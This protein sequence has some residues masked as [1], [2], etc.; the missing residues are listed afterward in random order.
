[1]T[2][3]QHPND[4]AQAQSWSKT[5][6]FRDDV[7]GKG[8]HPP[9]H[10]NPSHPHNPGHGPS[11]GTPGLPGP[12]H[13]GGNTHQ[14]PQGAVSPFKHNT[15]DHMSVPDL[16]SHLQRA[17]GSGTSK[18]PESVKD[19]LK[20]LGYSKHY[21]EGVDKELG[22]KHE[23]MFDA[24]PHDPRAKAS[25][26]QRWQYM[27][28]MAGWVHRNFDEHGKPI[29]GRNQVDS[30]MGFHRK[31]DS[32]APPLNPKHF[33][34][35]STLKNMPKSHLGKIF[36]IYKNSLNDNGGHYK[37]THADR[38]SYGPRDTHSSTSRGDRV[39]SYGEKHI[40][41]EEDAAPLLAD[42]HDEAPHRVNPHQRH[43]ELLTRFGGMP[44]DQLTTG[45]RADLARTGETH[46]YRQLTRDVTQ[47]AADAVKETAQ[48]L[49]KSAH[50]ALMDPGTY[51]V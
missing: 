48:D 9:A 34:E 40:Y 12:D 17:D 29:H 15:F 23:P 32:S 5:N 14:A 25:P 31:D 2:Q 50:D 11:S 37:E 19:L 46:R 4:V 27:A 51:R 13:T 16:K 28:K 35:G 10:S 1:M 26:E 36:G 18:P 6:P 7:L 38:V 20:G 21:I 49:G 42:H 24:R 30:G 39:K 45:E 8:A 41:T 43:D 33:E 44:F 22:H 3:G 47:R